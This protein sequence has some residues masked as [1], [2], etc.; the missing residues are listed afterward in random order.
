MELI[1]KYG[2]TRS[3]LKKLDRE[4]ARAEEALEAQSFPDLADAL[5]NFSIT[6][7]HIKDWLIMQNG[8]SD[9]EVHD[10][11]RN[12]PVL[13][14]CRDICNS[15]KHFEITRYE[16]GEVSVRST[17][18]EITDVVPN[19]EGG[20][21]IYGKADIWVDVGGDEAYRV[22]GFM[23]KVLE[24]WTRYHDEKGI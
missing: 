3:L 8:L 20:I 13:Q 22:L 6:A 7:Y 12:V 21:D 4:R 19:E 24:E 1:I 10:F 9:K 2:N 23:E 18:T 14:A 17:L 5:Y 16:P 11:I 15:K